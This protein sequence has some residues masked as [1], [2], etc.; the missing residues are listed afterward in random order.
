M[1]KPGL[2]GPS[3]EWNGQ[4]HK[5]LIPLRFSKSGNQ[6]IEQRYATHYVDLKRTAQLKAERDT[7]LACQSET[8]QDE[9]GISNS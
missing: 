9:G 3:D 2:C 8:S 1:Q 5:P 4:G 6:E 7:N